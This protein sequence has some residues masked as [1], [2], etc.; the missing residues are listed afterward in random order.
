MKSI[1][2]IGKG[3]WARKIISHIRKKKIFDRI[4][5]KTKKQTYCGKKKIKILPYYK[6]INIIHICSPLSTHY[7][8]IKKFFNHKKLII[9]KPFLKNLREFS[10]IEKKNFFI[11]NTYI[12]NYID[13]YNPLI[14]YIKKKINKKITKI[15]FEYS[16][17]KFYYKTKF[18]CIEDWL[19]HPLSVILFLFRKFENYKIIKKI[20]LKKQ[21]KYQ[22]KIEI[23]FN[24]KNILVII[25]INLN[26]KKTRKIS[27]YKDNILSFYV[28]LRSNKI[29]SRYDVIIKKSEDHSLTYLYENVIREKRTFYQSLTFYKKIINERINIIDSLKQN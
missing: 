9:E 10:I 27:L 5:I 22:E 26:K 14:N 25:L 28:D 18:S 24:Y 17:H 29:M 13:L 20:F 1:L 19:E 7:K 8:Y 23:H 12:V 15:I 16:N 3:K 21:K 6:K 11:K 4:Y 2:I